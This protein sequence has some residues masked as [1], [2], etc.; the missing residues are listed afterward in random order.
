MW[1]SDVNCQGNDAS[2]RLRE[3]RGDEVMS[4]E[5]IGIYVSKGVLI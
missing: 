2:G 3:V 1:E 4:E 5:V